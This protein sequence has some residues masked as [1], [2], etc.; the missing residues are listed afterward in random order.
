M[1]S[2]GLPIQSSSPLSFHCLRP[3]SPSEALPADSASFPFILHKRSPS[4]SLAHLVLTWHHLSEDRNGHSS[5]LPSMAGCCGRSLSRSVDSLTGE[6]QRGPGGVL[7]TGGTGS[8]STGRIKPSRGALYPPQGDV[9]PGSLG[10][11]KTRWRL[12]PEKGQWAG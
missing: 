10:L 11:C 6:I 8:V 9:Y 5:P 4:T 2:E 3:A 12:C 7:R 1:Q